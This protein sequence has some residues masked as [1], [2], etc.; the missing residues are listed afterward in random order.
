MQTTIPDVTPAPGIVLLSSIFGVDDDIR[1]FARRYA[2]RG[3]VVVAPDLFARILPGALKRTGDDYS[4]A[5]DRKKKVD[6][7]QLRRDVKTTIAELRAMPECNG[8]VAA[9]GICFGGRYALL[10]AIDGDV[11]A[12]GAY[13]ASEAGQHIAELEHADAPISLHYGDSD[14]VAPMSEVNAVKRA[15]QNDPQAE[16]FVYPGAGHNFSIPTHPAYDAV[17]AQAAETR[18]FSMFDRLK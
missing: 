14:S 5:V 15:L 1:E 9:L 11:D 16:V 4:K 3:Y 13:H 7:D 18:V 6:V 8:K 12:A 17:A 10:A 2:Q